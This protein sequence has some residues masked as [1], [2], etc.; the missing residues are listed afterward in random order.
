MHDNIII[1]IADAKMGSQ[2][3]I[4]KSLFHYSLYV[5]NSHSMFTWTYNHD[6]R[7]TKNQRAEQ[8]WAT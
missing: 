6:R 4:I 7:R 8:T 2:A 3:Y 1:I 5:S